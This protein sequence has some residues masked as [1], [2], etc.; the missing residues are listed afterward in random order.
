MLGTL[1]KHGF[2]YKTFVP[3]GMAKDLTAFIDFVGVTMVGGETLA[4]ILKQKTQKAKDKLANGHLI[5]RNDISNILGDDGLILSKDIQLKEKYDYEGSVVFGATGSGKSTGFYIPNLLNPDLKGSIIAGDPTGELF[6]ATSWYQQNI[7]GRKVLKFS[8]LE[9]NYSEKYNLLSSCKT[10]DE[11][12]ELASSLLL[13]GGLAIELAS[14]K[15]VQGAEWL[16]MSEGILSAALIYSKSLGYPFDNVE[17]ALR[18]IMTLKTKELDKLFTDSK[19]ID[20]ITEWNSFKIIGGAERTEGSIKITLSSN[21]R[22]F[23][24]SRI[25]QVNSMCTFDF[26]DFRKEPTILYLTYPEHKANY[27]SPYTAPFLTKMLDTLIEEY[28]KDSLP[29]H[30]FFDEF[31]DLGM[32]LGMPTKARTVRK[33]DISINICIQGLTQ[34]LQVYG[35]DNGYS[36]LNNLKTKMIFPS[37]S[38]IQALDYISQLCGEKEIEVI[39]KTENKNGNSTSHSKTKISMF[40]K[41]DL[42]CLDDD[43][44]LILTSNKQPILTTQ[45][46]YYNNTEYKNKIKEPIEIKQQRLKRYDYLDH[47]EDLKI[48]LAISKEND[49]DIRKDLFR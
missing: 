14:G 43:A 42:R 26:E 16:Q 11:V 27:I 24:D 44:L 28:N 2:F 46:T 22:L 40:S 32:I 17:F 10:N 13:N 1:L 15:K 5:S 37:M 35:K 38:D 39:N 36:I 41:S 19:N 20:C 29:I 34:L 9:P 7:C 3:H 18:L 25:S 48:D 49:F 47:I 45:N 33:R 6:N 4:Y 30:S 23:T 21:L 31:C 12:K 8:P